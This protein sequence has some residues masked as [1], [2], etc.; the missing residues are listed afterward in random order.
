VRVSYTTSTTTYTYTTTTTFTNSLGPCDYAATQASAAKALGIEVFVIGFGVGSTEQCN[1][2]AELSSS[3]YYNT[4]ATAFLQS[5]A[6]DASHFYNQ[7]KT[8]D[9][10]PIF[11]AIGSALTSG[12]KLVQ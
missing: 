11:N 4:Y 12:S 10:T 3:A 7:P 8:S 1:D 9:L 5:L 6:T 2:Y